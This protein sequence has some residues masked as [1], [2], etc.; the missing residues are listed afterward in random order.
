MKS[1]PNL[2]L[3]VV[4]AVVVVLAVVAWAVSANRTPPPLEPGSPEATVQAYLRAVGDGD[5]EAVVAL[6]APELGCSA[7]LTN[8]YEQGVQS[9]VLVTSRISGD[10]ATVVFEI[11]EYGDTPLDNWSH[12]ES[13]DLVRGDSGW[14]IGGNPWPVFGCE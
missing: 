1:R 14:L 7:P 11:T 10:T 12:R 13:F 9:S 4:T 5:D 2:V 6:L 3:A 8:P